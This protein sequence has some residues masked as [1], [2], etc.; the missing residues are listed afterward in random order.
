MKIIKPNAVLLLLLAW[1]SAL[2]TA[3][4]A[5]KKDSLAVF[6]FTGG[7][8]SDGESIAN[9][10]TRQVVLRNC[11]SNTRLITRAIIATMNFEQRFQRNSGLTDADTIFELGKELKA[12]HVIAGYITKFGDRNL[13]IVSIMDVESLQQIA[14]DYRSYGTIEEI[15][16][17][18]PDMAAQLAKAVTRDT[19]GLLGLSVPPFVISPEVNQNDAM[20]LAQILSCDLANSGNYAVL[21]RTDG[22]EIV[23]EE[24][25]RQRDGA[26]D[27]DRIKRLGVGRNAKYVLAGSVEKLGTL[28]KFAADIL[29]IE[30][31]GYIDGHEEKYIDFAQG[32]ELVP[33]LAAKLSGK[34]LTSS[35][36]VIKIAGGTFKMGS[37]KKEPLRGANEV[38]HKVKLRTFNI[39]KF[40]VTQAEYESVMGT[41]PSIFKGANLPVENVSWY[42]AVEFCNKLSLR[43][44]LTPAYTID[45]SRSDPNNKSDIDTVRWL[46]TWNQKAN[47]Y[48]L[49]TEAEW[50]YACRAGTTTPF[51]FGNNITTGNANYNGTIPY[52]KNAQGKFFEKTTI[53]GSFAPNPWGLYD[54]HGNVYEW[55]WDWFGNYLNK[56]QKN[57]KGPLTGSSR[58]YRGGAWDSEG[59][60][61]RSAFRNSAVPLYRSK[62]IGIRLVRPYSPK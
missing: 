51:Y 46:V 53:V 8:A 9:S 44:R 43:E 48:R 52:N 61:L 39:G 19:N 57:P 17:L 26:T 60:Y 45:K 37:H 16:A 59:Q 42:D 21:P 32:F 58:V 31:G 40:E 30:D 13:V 24:H 47:G 38:Q 49:P 33:M 55:C 22:L 11:F 15:N 34:I 18:I 23:M 7:A 3:L 20:T 6:A 28:N 25:K 41:N 14:G 50:E 54:M 12:S 10:L 27:Q 2:P 5:Q 1:L 4:F 29:D 36:S 56:T 62:N 35:I